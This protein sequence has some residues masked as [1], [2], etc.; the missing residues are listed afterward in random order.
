MMGLFGVWKINFLFQGA[1]IVFSG[2]ML[3]F[4]GVLKIDWHWEKK[5]YVLQRKDMLKVENLSY[6]F[7]GCLISV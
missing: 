6:F 3:I 2:S 7:Q 5:D 1:R 4:R